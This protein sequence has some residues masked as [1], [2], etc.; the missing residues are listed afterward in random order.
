MKCPIK[1]AKEYQL[2]FKNNLIFL[3]FDEERIDWFG[4]NKDRENLKREMEKENL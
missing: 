1:Q 2:G 4:N 3:G